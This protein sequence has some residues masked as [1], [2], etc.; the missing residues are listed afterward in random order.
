[1]LKNDKHLKGFRF[2]IKISN[3]EHSEL[4]QNRLFELDFQWY[5]QPIKTMKYT[6]EKYILI[7]LNSNKLT[8]SDTIYIKDPFV[9][10]ITYL[11]LYTKEFL[12]AIGKYE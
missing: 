1:M 5:S 11:D 12:K 8:F 10:Q 7:P 6:S 3:P 9:K 2:F 4:V